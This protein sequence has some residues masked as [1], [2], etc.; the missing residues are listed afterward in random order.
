M[1]NLLLTLWQ[2][3]Q[4]LLGLILI[5]VTN[6]VE[7]KI[8]I[9]ERNHIYICYYHFERNTK[10]TKFISGVSLGKYI[11]LSDNNNSITTIKHEY[12][13][14]LQSEMLGI[15]YLFIIGIPSSLGNL[16]A[17]YKNKSSEW[18]YKQPWEKW[19]DELAGVER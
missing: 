11:L 8:C 9:D 18:Y 19:A 17:R 7:R 4:L 12:G 15:L 16:Y 13:H 10:F 1:K 2:F 6:A 3:P 14:S 5:K